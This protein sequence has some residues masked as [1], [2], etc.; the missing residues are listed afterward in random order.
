MTEKNLAKWLEE[1]PAELALWDIWYNHIRAESP[2]KVVQTPQG[3]QFL[4]ISENLFLCSE[5]NENMVWNLYSLS[6]DDFMRL[7]KSRAD[8]AKWKLAAPRAVE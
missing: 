3:E 6:L 5:P 2:L 8:V 4:R 7:T 1:M